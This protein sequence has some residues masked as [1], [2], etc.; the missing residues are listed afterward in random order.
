MN[1]I[2]LK[3]YAKINLSIDVLGKRP[4]GYHEVKMIMQTLMLHDI[5]IVKKGIG[6]I[7]I[8][9]S[10]KW[11]PKGE[12][13]IAYKAAALMMDKFGIKDGIDIN[14]KKSIPVSA[15]LAGGSADAAAVFK[16]INELYELGLNTNELMQLGK[17]IGADV[18]YCIVGGTA[19]AQGIGEKITLLSSFPCTDVLIIKPPFGVSTAWVYENLRLNEIHIR[20]DIQALQMGIEK[21][22]ITEVSREM[23][24]VLELVTIKRYSVIEKLK[25]Q[26][27]QNG[28]KGSLM[29]GS[30]P[31]VFGLFENK[32]AANKALENIKSRKMQCFLTKTINEEK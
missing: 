19:L 10:N 23:I 24:N 4:D 15:G 30:G 12:K 7:N 3:A 16:A 9:C 8:E 14:I 32:D 22:N 1:E 31:S 17:T 6:N 29:S 18:P 2:E 25:K 5:V 21:Q 26:L 11:I 27:I 13:N 20:P 28:A